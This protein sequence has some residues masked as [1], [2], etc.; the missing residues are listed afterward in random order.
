MSH[1]KHYVVLAIV[2][3]SYNA[4]IRTITGLPP[5]ADRVIHN[6]DPCQ[7][8]IWKLSTNY[9]RIVS[10]INSYIL[11]PNLIGVAYSMEF[12]FTFE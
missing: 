5:S 8:R 1:H 12:F 7:V 11:L 6:L 3:P 4:A 10:N 9:V 2:K